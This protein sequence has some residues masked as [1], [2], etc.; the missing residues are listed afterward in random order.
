MLSPCMG[1]SKRNVGCHSSC[2]EYAEY[3]TEVENVNKARKTFNTSHMATVTQ[4]RQA[5]ITRNYGK[6]WNKRKY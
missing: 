5:S 2:T 1:C 6:P 3:K 4:K